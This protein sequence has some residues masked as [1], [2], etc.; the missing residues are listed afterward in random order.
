MRLREFLSLQTPLMVHDH[1]VPVVILAFGLG[2]GLMG[3]KPVALCIGLGG[4]RTWWASID[5][6]TFPSPVQ[7]RPG[8]NGRAKTVTAKLP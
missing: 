8:P 2:A 1:D 5:S 4:G 6:L 7:S 3:G